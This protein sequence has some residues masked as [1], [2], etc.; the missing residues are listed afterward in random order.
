MEINESDLEAM[1]T[2]MD[3]LGQ[4]KS[5]ECSSCGMA[6]VVQVRSAYALAKLR[7]EEIERELEYA[8]RSTP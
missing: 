2:I 1:R 5:V 3:L 8:S 4:A 7:V 6:L